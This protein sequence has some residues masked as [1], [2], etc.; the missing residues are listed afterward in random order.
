[1]QSEFE[2]DPDLI[3]LN[4]AMASPWPRRTVRAIEA[5]SRESMTL[6][7]SRVA[8]W[9]PYEISLRM[10]YRRLLNADSVA[11]IALLKNTS[12]AISMVAF[13]LPWQSGDNIVLPAQE[14]PS[15]HVAWSALGE[16]GVELRRIDWG[17]DDDA[18]QALMAACDENTRLL[19]VSSVQFSAGFRM[20]LERLGEFCRGN[21]ILFCIDAIQ[22][23][24]ALPFDLSRYHADFVMA[25]AHKWQL[26]PE[27]MAV[28]WSNPAVRETLAPV[29][30]GWR[31]RQDM[32]HFEPGDQWTLETS[33]RR[34]E[35]GTTSQLNIRATEA[36]L[37]LL[38]DVGIEA[39]SS[40]I[41]DRVEHLRHSLE[42]TPG[43]SILSDLSPQRRS[44][45]L[46][47]RI[48]GDNEALYRHLQE[49]RVFCARR[50]GGI[51]FAPHFYTPMAQLDQA[52]RLVE[53]FS[54]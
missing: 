18:E 13:G 42:A 20:N 9:G 21:D 32:L 37:S 23:L 36:S 40:R 41:A 39:V 8:D 3:Y 14:F 52:V 53:A 47:F 48:A 27:G 25:G 34:F 4:H 28:F 24:G 2:L 46:T 1:M 6:G 45:I 54:S 26:A 12:E 43:V 10:R 49:Q 16:A 19:S 51:R 33:A 11:D 7:A 15:N 44:G 35:S 5:F 29:Q 22:H 31:S 30:L 17:P 50:L 38:E